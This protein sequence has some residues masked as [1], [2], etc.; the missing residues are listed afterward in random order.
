MIIYVISDNNNRK[1]LYPSWYWKKSNVCCGEV[2]NVTYFSMFDQDEGVTD[3]IYLCC[4]C[5]R[6]QSIV[7]WRKKC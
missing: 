5:C 2:L 4:M 1:I 6:P 3:I 7:K